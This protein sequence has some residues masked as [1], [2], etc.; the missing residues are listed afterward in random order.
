M[1]EAALEQFNDGGCTTYRSD[2]C[3]RFLP[4][5]EIAHSPSTCTFWNNVDTLDYCTFDSDELPGCDNTPGDR[6]ER[7]C[8]CRVTSILQNDYRMYSIAAHTSELIQIV[9]NI[10]LTPPEPWPA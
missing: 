1:S 9:G 6:Y 3:A 7:L 10:C 2:G 5:R 8:Q 4:S